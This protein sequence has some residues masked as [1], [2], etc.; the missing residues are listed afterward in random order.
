MQSN[1]NKYRLVNSCW[2]GGLR[3]SCSIVMGRMFP[4]LSISNLGVVGTNNFSVPIYWVDDKR[5]GHS[6]KDILS[7]FI[8]E[9]QDALISF[10]DGKSI[11]QSAFDDCYEAM[12]MS[13]KYAYPP[14]LE[15]STE[16]KIKFVLSF[17]TS[18]HPRALEL[19]LGEGSLERHHFEMCD[20]EGSTLTEY[21]ICNLSWTTCYVPELVEECFPILQQAIRSHIDLQRPGT[22]RLTIISLLLFCHADTVL[23]HLKSGRSCPNGRWLL[24]KYLKCLVLAGVDLTL[25]GAKEREIHQNERNFLDVHTWRIHR[26]WGHHKYWFTGIYSLCIKYGPTID[27]W[28]V[29]DDRAAYYEY[30]EDFWNMVES[31]WERLPGA[32][33][34]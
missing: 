26:D 5:Y 31:P 32:W 1:T 21:I 7:L 19:A 13:L 8:H 30:A 15:R 22:D 34:D 14:Y 20:A 16:D 27:D 11:L 10:G 2:I 9:N 6:V 23:R 3:L 29:W 33:I 12:E 4:L 18:I 24:K 25:Y 17:D 28:D